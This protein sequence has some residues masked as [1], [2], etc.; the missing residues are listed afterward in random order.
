VERNEAARPSSSG[1]AANEKF[2]WGLRWEWT[3][4]AFL[5][6]PGFKKSHGAVGEYNGKFMVNQMVF[7]RS[8]GRNAARAQSANIQKFLPA[9]SKMAVYGDKAGKIANHRD[10]ETQSE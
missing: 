1:E 7:A 10:A 9:A 8:F 2:N 3:N 5:P 4:S 6:Y